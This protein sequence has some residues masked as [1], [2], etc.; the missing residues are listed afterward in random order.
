MLKP[1]QLVLT[2]AWSCSTLLNFNFDGM[3]SVFAV[4]ISLESSEISRSTKLH[5]SV[6]RIIFAKS[7]TSATRRSSPRLEILWIQHTPINTFPPVHFKFSPE[8]ARLFGAVSPPDYLLYR[9][10]DLKAVEWTTRLLFLLYPARRCQTPHALR[11]LRTWIS[12]GASSSPTRFVA[13]PEDCDHVR[14]REYVLH[15]LEAAMDMEECCKIVGSMSSRCRPVGFADVHCREI[16]RGQVVVVRNHSANVDCTMGELADKG[17]NDGAEWLG[18]AAHRGLHPLRSRCRGR[19]SSV[20]SYPVVEE[21]FSTFAICLPEY[22]KIDKNLK[23]TLS[24][25]RT[26]S[27]AAEILVEQSPGGVYSD[28][29]HI[30]DIDE[31]Y[32]LIERDV[33]VN[34]LPEEAHTIVNHG[35]AVDDSIS[36]VHE[37][38]I[39]LLTAEAANFNLSVSV[40]A[41]NRLIS[42]WIFIAGHRSRLRILA[43]TSLHLW[44]DAIA[45]PYLSTGGTDMRAYLNITHAIY[46]FAG[47]KDTQWENM[48]TVVERLHVCFAVL[49]GLDLE[50]TAEQNGHISSIE[51][52]HAFIQ[53]ADGF[54]EGSGEEE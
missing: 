1:A 50:L 13:A 52:I 3:T 34:A 36:R 16:T 5:K 10:L 46:R 33:K 15:W 7:C 30:E 28:L 38:Y 17:T 4:Q 41:V 32:F 18:S 8:N 44:P 27:A 11:T 53:N 21:P 9:A 45:T 12:R 29:L 40:R 42:L 19:G 54:R 2:C 22:G 37:R 39:K 14:C 6:A 47:I 35:V 31:R 51:W 49:S 48:H 25:Q 43:G 20:A 23:H 26:W 24:D